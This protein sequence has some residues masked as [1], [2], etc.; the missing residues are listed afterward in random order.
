MRGAPG[1]A[2]TPARLI[3]TRVLARSAVAIAVKFAND[4]P[5]R[6][7]PAPPGAKPTIDFI[8]STT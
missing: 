1:N 5:L 7:N 3:S 4:P 2:A 8:H 6:S